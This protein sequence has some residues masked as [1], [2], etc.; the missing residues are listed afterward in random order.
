MADALRA[1]DVGR[2]GGEPDVD[3]GIS[4]TWDAGLPITLHDSSFKLACIV[5][6]RQIT[7]D[8]KAGLVSTEA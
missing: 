1:R 6:A 4:L 8:S 5:D 3:D 7:W 2:R